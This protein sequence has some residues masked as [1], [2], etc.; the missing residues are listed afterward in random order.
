MMDG[1]GRVLS[2]GMVKSLRRPRQDD[3]L[4][5][6]N[7]VAIIASGALSETAVRAAHKLAKA[8]ITAR[9]INGRSV[10]TS[11]ANR[12]SELTQD[13]KAVVILEEDNQRPGSK[14]VP[15]GAIAHAAGSIPTKVLP[16]NTHSENGRQ[17][18]N[19]NANAD[20]IVR[21]ILRLTERGGQNR[22]ALSDAVGTADATVTSAPRVVKGGS[23][24]AGSH[25]SFGFPET[26]LR[27][28]RERI[29]T[30][31]VSSDV[32]EWSKLYSRVGRRSSF[33]WQWASRGAELTTLPCVAPEWRAHVRDTKVLSIII[34]VL[35]DDVADEARRQSFLETL[36]HVVQCQT[37]PH[38]DSIPT[39]ERH[40][41][42]VTLR[43]SNL[44][45]RR[46]REYP[47]FE[48]YK[49][50]HRYDLMQYI[51]TMR[52]ASLLN[53]HLYLLNPA[54]HE[55]YFPHNM[56]MMSFATLDLMCSPNFE[57]NE[58]GRVR[59]AVWHG[60]CMGRIGNLLCT[61]RRELAEDDFTSDIFAR[62]VA[63]GDLTVNQLSAENQAEIDEIIRDGHYEEY[64]L[65]RWRYHR[66]RF[67]SVAA[68]VHSVDLRQ[69]LRG[70]E[71]FFL[72]HMAS[73]GLI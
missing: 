13:A 35:L 33:L 67:R 10:E 64:F 37:I 32:T 54:E 73:R 11:D 59:E 30:T 17:R 58:L 53:Q 47:Y 71:R 43:L 70:H 31:R 16:L 12:L 4:A 51:N 18:R 45:E 6:E 66:K 72:M 56:H 9:V 19:I 49:E 52:Y 15:N 23:G 63:M 29:R 8:G 21:S 34:C 38:L 57:M 25:G 69:C 7:E 26:F 42:S 28:E 48:V 24:S 41:A 44:Y 68:A 61:W 36:L 20:I 22:P 55:I 39:P 50:L 40:Y 14:Q 27:R 60:Q 46:I 1:D 62:A 3:V 5:D 65:R 2:P